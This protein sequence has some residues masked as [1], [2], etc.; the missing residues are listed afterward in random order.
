[1]LDEYGRKIDY[2]RISVT[3][4]CNLR[5]RYC[6]PGSGVEKKAHTEILR[7]EE[8][9][10][11]VRAAA[12]LG[13]KKIRFTGGEPLVRRGLTELISR[14]SCIPGIED[15]GLTTNGV[16]LKEY[17]LPLWQAGLRRVNI[18]IDS[19]QDAKYRWIT[20][21]GELSGVMEG[22][23]MA[24][25]AGFSPIKLNVVLV[26]GFND[27]EIKDFVALTRER[28]IEVRFI[29]L[30]PVG[31]AADWDAAHF[32]PGSEVLERVPELTPLP[33]KGRG[34]I[35][36]YYKLPGSRG[37][38]GLISPLSDCFCAGCNRI[39]LTADGKL[40]PCLLSNFELDI[41][42]YETDMH[43]FLTDAIRAKPMRHHIHQQDAVPRVR[44]MNQIGG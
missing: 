35:A 17:A 2:L 23:E 3:D 20:R 24:M 9:E 27:D 26:G 41:K 43:R 40:K 22:I 19:L 11:V 6:M 42:A 36:R 32:L 28:Q 29:E 33:F 14:I 25:A 8:I 15:I 31:E 38:V 30:M 37:D 5:C 10:Q 7:L 16:L 18:S 21:V 39:R 4:L 12:E 13:F 44:N 1:M 34:G